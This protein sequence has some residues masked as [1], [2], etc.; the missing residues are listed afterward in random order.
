MS[1]TNRSQALHRWSDIDSGRD[2]FNDGGGGGDSFI[3]PTAVASMA[4]TTQSV[5]LGHLN[6]SASSSGTIDEGAMTLN[7]TALLHAQMAAAA[8]DR[9]YIFDQL[10]IKIIFIVCY[11]AVFVCCVF[12]K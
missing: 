5:L 11:V 8:D 10:N 12:G 9:D 2:K 3:D 1:N 7:Q 4:A 6:Q